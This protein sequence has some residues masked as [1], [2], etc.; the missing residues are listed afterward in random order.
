M[1]EETMQDIREKVLSKI[2]AGEI[3]MRPKFYF[4]LQIALLGIFAFFVF[5]LSVLLVSYILFSVKT[6]GYY[7]LLGFGGRGLYHFFIVFPWLILLI[8]LFFL[9]IFDSLLKKFKFAYHSPVIYLFFGTL[10]LIST[11][12]TLINFDSFHASMM[13]RA[14][15]DKLPLM[16]AMYQGIRRSNGRGGV[17][18]GQITSLYGNTFEIRLNSLREDDGGRTIKV[19]FPSHAS[20]TDFLQIGEKVF[21]AGEVVDGEIRAYGVGRLEDNY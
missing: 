7:Y 15:Q 2:E 18:Q 1:K 6:G 4:A 13:K 20:T 3:R 10:I 5:I 16:G 19:I 14:E 8:D 9:L 12:A 21:V 11:L 17:F